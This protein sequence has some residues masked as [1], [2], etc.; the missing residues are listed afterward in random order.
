MSQVLV[1]GVCP[2]EA[3]NLS[4]QYPLGC[5][6]LHGHACLA[7]MYMKIAALAREHA[8]SRLS[9]WQCSAMFFGLVLIL[10]ETKVAMLLRSWSPSFA[11]LARQQCAL[12]CA[13]GLNKNLALLMCRAPVALCQLSSCVYWPTAGHV[14]ADGP[15]GQGFQ[16]ALA[17][18]AVS[19]CTVLRSLD[20]SYV[21]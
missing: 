5:E 17:L 10:M 18:S 20:A 3:P 16:S 8:S 2:D 9:D 21:C 15:H 7:S 4:E 1:V 6:L 19:S 11:W 12:M 13:R 14:T